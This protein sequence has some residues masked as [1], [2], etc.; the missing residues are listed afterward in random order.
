MIQTDLYS[1]LSA[2]FS[3]R[4]YPLVAPDNVTRPFAVY[5]R[6]S[7]SEATIHG[8]GGISE[9]RMQLDI[10]ADTYAAALTLATTARS[11]I[12]ASLSL[13]SIPLIE[14]DDYEPETK[15][16]RIFMEFTFWH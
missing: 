8:A 16:Y 6:I 12:A 1:L 5:Q 10:F 13:T 15:L 3:G 14:A 2:T 9:T 11:V 7:T 4:L